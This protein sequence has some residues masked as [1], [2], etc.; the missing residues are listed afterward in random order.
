MGRA[1]PG[2]QRRLSDVLGM[3]ALPLT[4]DVSLRCR[5]RSKRAR[6]GHS[7][8]RPKVF[9]THGCW[10]AAAAPL[11]LAQHASQKTNASRSKS[12][13]ARVELRQV[14]GYP[15]EPDTVGSVKPK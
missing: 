7:T 15:A 5:E 1:A 6:S 14:L 2:Q 3:S 13:A 12:S 10:K 11:I 9:G 8:N 4:P